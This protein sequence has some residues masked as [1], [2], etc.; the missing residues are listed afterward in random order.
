M[1]VGDTIG[2]G[3]PTS[4]NSLL[5]ALRRSSHTPLSSLAVHFHDTYGQALSN[6]YVSLT[7]GITTVDSSVSGLGGCPYAGRQ[8]VHEQ[9]MRTAWLNRCLCMCMCMVCMAG[10]ASGNVATEDV[11][12]MLNG[13]GI[14]TGVDLR[15]LLKVCTFINAQLDRDALASS[16]TYR[17][18][19]ANSK[20]T[21]NE[22]EPMAQ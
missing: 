20:K 11:V 9:Q 14:Q 4:T 15:E 1:C 7:H 21:G 16:K 18:L 5:T 3:T 2:I 10:G 17:A 8:R 12:Y 6:I 19:I 13:L 22:L